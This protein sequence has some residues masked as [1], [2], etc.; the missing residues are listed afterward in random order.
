MERRRI[1]DA[2]DAKECLAAATAAGQ[3]P[4]VWARSNG[5]NARSLHC[6]RLAPLKRAQREVQLVELVPTSPVAIAPSRYLVHA[7]QFRVEVEPSFDAQ[8]LVKLLRIV[9]QC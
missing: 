6:W 7:G 1:R 5:V 3:P 2:D 8:V 4:T 9:T